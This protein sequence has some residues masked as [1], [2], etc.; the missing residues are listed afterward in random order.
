MP[1]K[2]QEKKSLHSQVPVILYE[3]PTGQ[4]EGGIPFPYIEVPKDGVM[5]PVLF[6]FEYK[7]TGEFEPDDKGNPAAIIDQMLHKF[8]D[9]EHLKEK[10]SPGLYDSVRVALGMKPLAEAK[11]AGKK[12]MDKVQKNIEAFDVNAQRKKVEEERNV[13]EANKKLAD[14]REKL[15]SLQIGF[16]VADDVDSTTKND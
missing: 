5:P 14:M 16:G 8:V 6:I 2:K 11:A 15:A 7:H 4:N 3:E 12:I 9:L 1:S 10:L 13:A